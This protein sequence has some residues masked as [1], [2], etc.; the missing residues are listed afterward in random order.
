MLDEAAARVRIAALTRPKALRQ[1]EERL[2]EVISAKEEAI[3]EQDFENACQLRQ[4]EKETRAEFDVK[5]EDWR[6]TALGASGSV[7]EADVRAVLKMW[8][9]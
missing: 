5:L 4:R 9:R 3:R 1:L 7:G 6:E 8:M 2:E